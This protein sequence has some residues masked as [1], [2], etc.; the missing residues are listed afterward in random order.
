M[1]KIITYSLFIVFILSAVWN[2]YYTIIS[3]ISS[4]ITI[5]ESFIF[6]NKVTKKGT[7]WGADTYYSTNRK[8]K[9]S[10][11][12]FDYSSIFDSFINIHK[13]LPDY[14]NYKE[15]ADLISLLLKLSQ[16]STINKRDTALYIPKTIDTYWNLSC[17]SHMPPFVGPA[18]ANY[19]M[20]EGLPLRDR[21]TSCYSH[22]ESYGYQTYELL[23]RK[24]QYIEMNHSEICLHAK[25]R[26]FSKIIQIGRNNE[27][28]F[29]IK[30]H[31]CVDMENNIYD[32]QSS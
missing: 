17:D 1:I 6:D 20:I 27:G 21:N 28:G 14:S 3:Y 32:I 19:V 2:A 18:V 23:G 12:K 9:I 8:H 4:N 10:L 29:L 11:I 16:N 15:E 7:H 13:K 25:K 26:G 24:A 5:R 30:H 22:F 31:K